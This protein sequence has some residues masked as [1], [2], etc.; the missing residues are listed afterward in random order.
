MKQTS[1]HVQPVKPSSEKHNKREKE[2]DY[3]RKDLTPTNEYWESRSQSEVLAED[4]RLAK[5][6]TGR[7]MQAKATP[8][9]E[10]VVVID[11]HTTMDDLKKLADAYRQTFGI[12]CFQIAIHRDEGHKDKQGNWKQNLHAHMVFNWFNPLTGKSIKLMQGKHKAKDGTVFERDDMSRMQ[13]IAAEVLHMGRGVSS[14]RK[15]LN[16]IQYKNQEQTKQL[17]QAIADTKKQVEIQ[18]A[19]IKYTMQV[20]DHLQETKQELAATKQLQQQ[21]D[22][23]LQ[24]LQ[25]AVRQQEAELQK[26]RKI[27]ENARENAQIASKQREV[28]NSQSKQIN[29]LRM[30]KTS[31][32]AQNAGINLWGAVK[33]TLYIGASAI[34][35]IAEWTFD[36]FVPGRKRTIAKLKDDLAQAQ[37]DIQDWRWSASYS[38]PQRDERFQRLKDREKQLL[39]IIKK[40]SPKDYERIK[41]EENEY[42]RQLNRPHETIED[43]K[44]RAY[45]QRKQEEQRKQREQTQQRQEPRRGGFRLG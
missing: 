24:V 33:A 44:R 15:H 14:D 4:K 42:Q 18:E 38:N 35:R 32:K 5:K 12:D 45:E 3:V 16:A 9:R 21:E 34:G 31:L 13:D 20:D 8:I 26:N 39:E 43:M 23:N 29:A 41:N 10:A 22:G 2:L 7:K 27:A 40:K 11:E 30:R 6:L 36:L 19:T 37:K 1:V 25:R 28:I 17:Q